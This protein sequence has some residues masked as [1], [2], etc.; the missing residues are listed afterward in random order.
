MRSV[1]VSDLNAAAVDLENVDNCT[2]CD[3]GKYCD[4][5]G[6]MD[7][8]GPCDAGYLCYRGAYTSGPV[9]GITGERLSLKETLYPTVGSLCSSGRWAWFKWAWFKWAWFKWAW[10]KSCFRYKIK[11]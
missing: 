3:P 9:D 2:L 11:N 6:L 8:R 4:T 7:V 1:K 5:P 10:F